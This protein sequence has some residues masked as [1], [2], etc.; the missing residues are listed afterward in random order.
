MVVAAVC[1]GFR[2]APV[3]AA[4]PAEQ[5]E[6]PPNT[7]PT[8]VASLSNPPRRDAAAA[9]DP[10]AYAPELILRD[11]ARA[12]RHALASED[13]M[14]AAARFAAVA[15]DFPIIA[16]H[17]TLLRARRL[18]EVALHTEAAAS[19]AAAIE[20]HHD[21]PLRPDFFETLGDAREKTGDEEGARDAWT[22]GIR[23]TRDSERQAVLRMKVATSLERTSDWEDAA[24]VYRRVWTKHASREQAG[25]AEAALDRVESKR[26]VTARS[27]NDWRK[28]ADQL[29]RKRYNEAALD[30]YD[31]ALRGKLKKSD[32][33]RAEN[34][35]AHTL[36]RLRRYPE[37]VKAFTAM[38]QKDDV[39]LWRARSLARSGE[40]PKAVSE[41]EKLGRQAK[42]QLS[43]RATYLA[44][45]LLDGRGHVER[46]EAHFDWVSRNRVSSGLSHAALWRLGW[47]AYRGGGDATAI[48]HFE[49]LLSVEEDTIGRL[50]TRYWRARALERRGDLAQATTEF[51]AM[52]NDFP[53]SYYGWRSRDRIRDHGDPSPGLRPKPGK[54]RLSH[55]DLERPKILLAAG[56]DKL[57]VEE[58]RRTGRRARG[59][60]DRLAM[61]QLFSEAEEYYD[62]LRIVVDA[63][64]ED[65]ARGPVPQL[66]ELWWH[67]WPSAFKA[68]VAA[69]TEAEN[70]VEPA[71]VYAIM[72]EESGYRPNILS[73][74]GARGLLQI[75]V[76][77]GDRLANR[78]GA[79]GYEPD[80]LFEPETNIKLGAYYLAELMGRFDGR[81][82]AAI[83]SYNAGPNAVAEWLAKPT[84]VEDDLWVESIPYDQTRGY[85]KRVL[86]SFHA[87]RVLY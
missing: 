84:A 22:R 57:A 52:A 78:M 75:M 21:S 60:S 56:L 30:A 23:A 51:S 28:R 3:A 85:V 47:A 80:D 5:T 73:V 50:R 6:P 9:I 81:R 86:R 19:V 12:L 16:D 2:V 72:R 65:L 24:A 46:A 10:A 37:A 70:S 7:E 53:F 15:R 38:P 25:L 40:V 87:Y 20:R 67:A 34:Q 45:L 42:G 69:S 77:T 82:S 44:G 8:Q 54:P 32:R 55:D 17:A 4:A 63:Y 74:S 36:F 66:E 71:L 1:A 76:P 13:A 33:Q 14:V 62:A 48:G 27:A 83:A 49:R 43:V 26:K 59:L 11:P 41:F 31:E 35:R 79:S 64:T 68:L 61:A 58:M 39:P 18:S 29:Y